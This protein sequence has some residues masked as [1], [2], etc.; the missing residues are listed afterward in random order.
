VAKPPAEHAADEQFTRW[1]RD[2]VPAVEEA[3]G[4]AIAGDQ[5]RLRELLTTIDEKRCVTC[6]KAY[7]KEK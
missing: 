2:V 4:V 3:A 7:K 6:H 5:K 1:L